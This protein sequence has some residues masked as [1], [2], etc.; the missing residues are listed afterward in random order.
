MYIKQGGFCAICGTHKKPALAEGEALKMSEILCIDHCHFTGRVRGLICNNCNA[1]IGNL[2]D[3][4][5]NLEK[6]IY[7]L[8][9]FIINSQVV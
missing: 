6:A 2:K 3:S 1:G 5:K 4:I 8:K 7:Y 9:S